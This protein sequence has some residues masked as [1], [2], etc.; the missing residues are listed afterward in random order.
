MAR[1]QEDVR[2][3]RFWR[4]IAAEFL[5]SMFIVL[6]GCGAFTDTAA[7]TDKPNSWLAVKVA[8]AF[9]L[10]YGAVLYCVRNVGDA[11]LNPSVTVALLATRR[12]SVI[13]SL[14]YLVAQFVGA[15][16]G[17]ALLL[18]VTS[19]PLRTGAGRTWP[20]G[21]TALADDVTEGHAF[22]V[23]FFATFL[24]V[25]VVVS[26]YDKTKLDEQTRTSAP[27][28]VIGLTYAAVTLFAFPYTGASINTA[29]SFGPALV[30]AVWTDHWVFWFGPLIGGICGG[31]IY[32]V[33]FSTKSSFQRITACFTVFH[34]REDTPAGI[35]LKEKDPEHGRVDGDEPVVAEKLEEGDELE[36]LAESP[37]DPNTGEHKPRHFR[38]KFSCCSKQT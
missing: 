30:N 22:G 8:L 18:A 23:E 24:F 10:T 27:P 20:G 15:I 25:F 28:V 36:E 33:I 19:A 7:T 1:L 6:I 34:K 31:A 32:D 3:L 14:L 12:S 11:H 5:G 2:R 29:R 13:R 16:V 21:C 9:G 35:G 38:P 17:A 4:S 26:C 37:A